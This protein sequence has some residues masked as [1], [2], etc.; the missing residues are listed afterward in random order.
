MKVFFKKN[1]LLINNIMESCNIIVFGYKFG[2][3]VKNYRFVKMI[4]V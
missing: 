4:M 2:I 1:I 3:I